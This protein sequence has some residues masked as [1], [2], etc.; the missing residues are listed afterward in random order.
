[1]MTHLL[2]TH[3]YI[4]LFLVNTNETQRQ[5]LINNASFL[6]TDKSMSNWPQ[7]PPN[8]HSIAISFTRLREV[9]QNAIVSSP[10]LNAI[11]LN[12]NN[13]RT[14][15]PDAFGR[16]LRVT[17]VE[18]MGNNLKTMPNFCSFKDSLE[19]L[20]LQNNPFM[21]LSP[22][23]QKSKNHFCTCMFHKITH[24]NF[25]NCGLDYVPSIVLCN[26]A[27]LK[28]LSLNDNKFKT[29]MDLSER[30]TMFTAV[31]T[32]Y[33]INNILEC[34]CRVKWIKKLQLSRHINLQFEYNSPCQEVSGEEMSWSEK[35][36]ESFTCELTTASITSV[37]ETEKT[38]GE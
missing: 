26:K 23:G 29:I 32:L 8:V 10:K 38:Q 13:I 9:P 31:S 7:V 11:Y 4:L 18:I 1:M 27:K 37:K 16:G 15:H 3:Y 14:I 20:K 28:F 36:L 5:C 12:R 34:D 2:R 22:T 30:F 35:P 6:C 33:M 19:I 24:L 17:Y 25:N 21:C